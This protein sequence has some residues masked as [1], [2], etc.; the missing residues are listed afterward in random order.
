MGHALLDNGVRSLITK[1]GTP[2]IPEEN[3]HSRN[4]WSI[5]T[6]LGFADTISK[7]GQF[8]SWIEKLATIWIKRTFENKLR[9]LAATRPAIVLTGPRQTGKTAILRRTFPQ[10]NF[11]S[12]DL[13]TIADQAEQNPELFMQDHPAPLIIDEVQYAPKLFRYLKILI[14]K[15]RQQ[16]GQLILTGSQKYQ[17]MKEVTE[18]LAGRVAVLEFDP[19]SYLELQDLDRDISL[20]AFMLKG[21]LPELY[22]ENLDPFSFFQSYVASYLERDLRQLLNV[23]QLRDFERFLRGCALRSGQVLN[24]S[25]LAKDVGISPSTANQWL[26]ALE[27]AGLVKL[28][29]PWFSNQG[30]RMIKSPKIYLNDTGLLCFLLNIQSEAELRK[31][32]LVGHIW[33]TCVFMELRKR[34]NAIDRSKNLF[35]YRDRSREVDFLYHQG[36]LFTLGEAKYTSNPSGDHGDG[37]SYVADALGIDHIETSL[38]FTRSEQQVDIKPGM[39]AWPFAKISQLFQ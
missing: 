15:N 23:G 33:E 32:P 10:H 9:N 3:S 22:A 7:T 38:L 35:F 25:D 29:E 12:L 24:K 1:T 37:L 2:R 19:L 8:C 18:S 6:L 14:D 21:G 26:S 28:L 17:L 34:L 20:E 31:S 30:K 11:V 39:T 5:F 4:Q 27:A 36:G 16:K 13:P